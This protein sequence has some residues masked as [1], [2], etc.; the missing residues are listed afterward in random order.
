MEKSL[1]KVVSIYNKTLTVERGYAGTT[2]AEIPAGAVVEVQFVEGQEGADA[3]DARYKPRKRVS[4]ITQIFDE[5]I[6]IT[7]TA[8]VVSNYG[9]DDLYE[10]EK[11]K[12]QARTCTATRKSCN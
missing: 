10:Y 8:A 2:P 9:I 6:S 5:T 1:I 12:R 4:N 7:G 3:R 11:Q